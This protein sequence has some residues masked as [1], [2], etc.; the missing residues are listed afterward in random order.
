MKVDG[1]NGKFYTRDHPHEIISPYVMTFETIRFWIKELS[2]NPEYG[3]KPGGGHAL[4]RSLGMTKGSTKRLLTVGWIWPRQQVRL[5]ARIREILD[6]YIV[7]RRLGLRTE[8]VYTNPPQPPVTTV[9]SRAIKMQA[10]PTIGLR[11]VAQDHGPPLRL[12]NFQRAFSEAIEWSPDK[13]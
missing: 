9:K 2:T 4:E 5:T 13:K 1:G 6:G 8:G 12:P 7:P 3:W 11:F 10:L